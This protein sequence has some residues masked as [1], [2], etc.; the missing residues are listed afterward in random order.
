MKIT[1]KRPLWNKATGETIEVG[2]N[3]G[4]WALNKG[5]AEAEQVAE[6][7]QYPGLP[8]HTRAQNKA[9]EPKYKRNK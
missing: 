1:L 4:T 8:E 7:E 5:Y 3:F 2:D 6:A 9:I